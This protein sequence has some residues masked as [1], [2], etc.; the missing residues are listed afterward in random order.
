MTTK[1]TMM[2]SNDV[3]YLQ[4]FEANKKLVN[5]IETRTMLNKMRS[6]IHKDIYNNTTAITKTEESLKKIVLNLQ[7][8]IPD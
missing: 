3:K 6:Q 1:K 8:K 4:L 7:K 2:K 5:L